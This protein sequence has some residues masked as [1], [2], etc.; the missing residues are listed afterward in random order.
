MTFYGRRLK[1]VHQPKRTM[2]RLKAVHQPKRTMRRLK[3]VHQPE[4]TMR[5][6]KA[7]H[8]RDAMPFVRGKVFRLKLNSIRDG[9]S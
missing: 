3:A 2:R 7:V 1:A 5:R 8:Q 6:L 9:H 4:R